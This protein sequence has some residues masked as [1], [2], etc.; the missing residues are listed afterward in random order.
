MS[1]ESKALPLPIDYVYQGFR[2]NPSAIAASDDR[3]TI[4]YQELQLRSEALA[5]L[6][7]ER[8]SKPC[9]IALCAQNHIDHLVSFLAILL[10]GHCWVPINPK[11]GAQLN[12][13]L[14]KKSQPDLVLV[15][16]ESES[17]LADNTATRLS[18]RSS[19]ENSTAKLS[20]KFRGQ[21]FTPKRA[22]ADDIFGIKFTGGTTGEPKGVMQSHKNVAAVV[23]N[24]QAL[25]NFQNSDGNLAVAPLTH[26]GSHYI[27]PLLAVGGRQVLLPQANTHLIRDAFLTRGA[28]VSFMPPT[29]IYKIMDCGAEAKSDF[30]NLRHL[31]YSAAPMPPERIQQAIEFFGSK[32]STVYG[33]TEA[34]M[35]ISAMTAEDMTQAALQ[36]SVGR[37]CLYSEIATVNA[38]GERLPAGEIGEIIARGDIVMAGYF[39]E[40]E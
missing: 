3:E 8:A 29:L 37:A 27:L 18:L 13:Q 14:L 39:Q 22:Q 28:T 40:P 20:Q 33:Q 15:D 23:E 17:T 31:T 38:E 7:Q 9:R 24:M 19:E 34:P 25:F 21:A 5:M 11:N 16:P 2:L 32:L 36:S 4:S 26:G 12:R 10:A 1:S 35:T 30:K 6:L